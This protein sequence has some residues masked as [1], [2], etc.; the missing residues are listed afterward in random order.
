M[1]TYNFKNKQ[2][3]Q[4][5]ERF[6]SISA[7]EEFLKNNPHLEQVHM[8]V[9]IVAGVGTMEGKMSDGWK[10]VLSKIAEANP[11]SPLSE[12]YTRKS[13]KEV[14]IDR[15]VQKYKRRVGNI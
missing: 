5:I 12:R 14:L 2:T 10:E 7:K 11:G 9:N 13:S 4:V 8:A 6:M 1:P 15:A 3:G